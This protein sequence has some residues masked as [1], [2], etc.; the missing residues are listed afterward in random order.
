MTAGITG[1]ESAV[2]LP[3]G[4]ENFELGID[5]DQM[6]FVSPTEGFI[7]L[8]MAGDAT[9]TVI[10]VT[11]DAGETWSLGSA[12]LDGA[13]ATDFLSAHELILYDG[14]QFH[15]TRDAARTWV[16]VSPD[17]AFGESFAS[18]EFV[19]TLAGWVITLDPTTSQRSL[20][21]THDGGAT[22]LPVIP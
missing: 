6:Q 8:R 16:T 14:E 13:G 4:A 12:V 18:M 2:D 19:N 21:R 5:R 22:W 10:Y 3:A 17:V 20:Y 9:R 11:Q 15:V 1:I 7:V